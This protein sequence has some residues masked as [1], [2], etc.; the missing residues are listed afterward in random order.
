MQRKFEFPDGDVCNFESHIEELIDQCKV[1][2]LKL[3]TNGLSV[4]YGAKKEHKID[5]S[6]NASQDT[7]KELA[8][9]LIEMT[10]VSVVSIEQ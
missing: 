8:E 3:T 9:T 4:C 10:S 6:F 5:I 2:S 1:K 7:L